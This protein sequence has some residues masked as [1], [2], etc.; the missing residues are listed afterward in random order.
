MLLTVKLPF[1]VSVPPLHV[2]SVAVTLPAPPSVPPLKVKFPA[3][4]DTPLSVNVPLETVT[5]PLSVAPPATV[6]APPETNRA[7]LEYNWPA[8]CPAVFTVTMGLA[9]ARSINTKSPATGA[10]P[11]AQ[12]VPTFQKP[13]VSTAQILMPA[14]L[15]VVSLRCR[16]NAPPTLPET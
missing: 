1:P 16:K 6:S 12:L 8:T 11:P 4:L 7:S 9:A 14:L 2:M 15:K 13:L 5:A 10:T 3:T